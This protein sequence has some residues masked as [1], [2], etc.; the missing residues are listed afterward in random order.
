MIDK[1]H[2]LYFG[3]ENGTY[4]VVGAFKSRE[5]ALKAMEKQ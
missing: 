2:L 3:I 4:D 5:N 1:V